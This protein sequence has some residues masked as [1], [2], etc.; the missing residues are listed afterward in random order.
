MFEVFTRKMIDISKLQ[1]E[2]KEDFKFILDEISVKGQQILEEKL[3]SSDEFKILEKKFR[4]KNLNMKEIVSE[5]LKS[6]INT[7]EKY[8]GLN[9]QVNGKDYNK[10][11]D[12]VIVE[13]EPLDE[14][15][16]LEMAEKQK[17]LEKKIIQAKSLKKNVIIDWKELME[18]SLND[19]F[20][21]VDE[22]IKINEKKIN[23]RNQN[24]E[25]IF[26]PCEEK[27]L[28]ECKVKMKE[29]SLMVQE[30]KSMSVNV[31]SKLDRYKDFIT[32]ESKNDEIIEK[33]IQKSSSNDIITGKRRVLREVVKHYEES[34]KLTKFL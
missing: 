8:V 13:T 33:R 11:P 19:E 16:M 3:N 29:I 7:L 23:E 22:F 26:D 18:A 24:T 27:D 25:S 30:L 32:S 12:Q 21:K 28:N 31:L 17:L 6:K 2:S 14:S 4:T 34:S 9:C 20:V 10:I 5:N 1:F 15:L